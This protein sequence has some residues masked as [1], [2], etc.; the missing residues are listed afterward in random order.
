MDELLLLNCDTQKGTRE[1]RDSASVAAAVV[2]AVVV[3]DAVGDD[4]VIS[5]L[6]SHLTRFDRRT[7]GY[8]QSLDNLPPSRR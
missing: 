2:E 3:R 4:A 5:P 1:T 8:T 6:P 7:D